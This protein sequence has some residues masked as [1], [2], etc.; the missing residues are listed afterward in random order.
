MSSIET[1]SITS[2]SKN[3][4]PKGTEK[5]RQY[6]VYDSCKEDHCV[7]VI[8]NASS[9]EKVLEYLVENWRDYVSQP[10]LEDLF[11]DIVNDAPEVWKPQSETLIEDAF[12]GKVLGD[13]DQISFPSLIRCYISNWYEIQ[14]SPKPIKIVSV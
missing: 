1:S 14:E 13:R 10:D 6:V 8:V 4:D 12:T 11:I 2:V 9:E 3:T 7:K 5:K